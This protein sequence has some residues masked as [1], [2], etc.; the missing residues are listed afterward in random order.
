VALSLLAAVVL[1]TLVMA[2]Y[3]LFWAA[4]GFVSEAR[5]AVRSNDAQNAS[6]L[7]IL[8]GMPAST[9]VSDSYIV[10]DY[11]HSREM[12]EALESRV[13]CGRSIRS[14]RPTTS[15]GWIPTPRWKS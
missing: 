9:I 8:S 10:S 14:R 5:F 4:D 13:G 6:V 7:G 12:V 2:L 15:P 3:F 11:I 1:P